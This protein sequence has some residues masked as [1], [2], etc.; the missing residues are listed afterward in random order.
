MRATKHVD[1]L[2]VACTWSVLVSDVV[3]GCGCVD[4]RAGGIDGG[5]EGDHVVVVFE[6]PAV[7]FEQQARCMRSAYNRGLWR[8]AAATSFGRTE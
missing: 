2:Q 7:I 8:D 6:A 5:E 1:V 4:A 3:G